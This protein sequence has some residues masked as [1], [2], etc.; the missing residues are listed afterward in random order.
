MQC[1]LKTVTRCADKFCEKV[2]MRRLGAIIG[3]EAVILHGIPR[4]TIDLD[5]LLFYG[6]EENHI[7]GLCR[8]FAAFLREELDA[9]FEVRAVAA[10]KDPSD[11]L[12]HDLIVITDTRNRFRKADILIANYKWELEGLLTMD[13]P[14]TG[15]FQPYP[16]PY[17]IGMK[18]MAGGV[19]DEED[20]RNLFLIMSD[21][22]KEK[23]YDI[24]RLIRRNKNL[25]KTLSRT[26]PG[27]SGTENFHEIL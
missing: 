20:I 3:G 11:P 1:L 23:A 9:R 8:A 15:P 18:L 17:L 7:T 4:T 24:A 2:N 14:H 25:T 13:S 5:I 26:R 22:E 19:T 16:K 27:L 6:D 21:A 10:S 12:R